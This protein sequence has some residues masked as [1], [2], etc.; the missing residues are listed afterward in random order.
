MYR[1]SVTSVTLE[2]LQKSENAEVFEEKNLVYSVAGKLWLCNTCK[3]SIQKG[4]ILCQSVYSNLALEQIP[5][6]LEQLNEMEARLIS[7]RIPFMKMVA[8]ARGGQ[9]SIHG[10]AVNVPAIL[11][12]VCSLLPRPPSE[13]HWYP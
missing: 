4:N 3:S 12:V 8:L 2:K 7:L 1:H 6:E 9:Q 5:Q 10:P 11:N 13:W